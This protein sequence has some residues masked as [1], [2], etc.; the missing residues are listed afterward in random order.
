[1]TPQ[2]AAAQVEEAWA[3]FY[4]TSVW[5]HQYLDEERVRGQA[6]REHDDQIIRDSLATVRAR[7]IAARKVWSDVKALTEFPCES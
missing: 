7:L 2:E 4:A 1:M 6:D 3:T 5:A